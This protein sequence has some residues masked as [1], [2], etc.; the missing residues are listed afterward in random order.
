MAW[1]AVVPGRFSARGPSSG[2][3][4]TSDW[5]RPR[6]SLSSE[7]TLNPSEKPIPAAQSGPFGAL[8]LPTI[9]AFIEKGPPAW[10]IPPPDPATL[11]PGTLAVFPVTVDEVTVRVPV[12]RSPPPPGTLIAVFPET[13]DDR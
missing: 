5:R 3:T 7:M 11:D 8:L 4:T 6:Q 13:V 12:L 2:S 9:E 10:W 1:V